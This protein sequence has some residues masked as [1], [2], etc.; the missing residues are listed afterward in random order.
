MLAALR[1]DPAVSGLAFARHFPIMDLVP[2]VVVSESL[3]QKQRDV[4]KSCRATN[5]TTQA[6]DYTSED[7]GVV[8]EEHD[9]KFWAPLTRLPS[10]RV[11]ARDYGRGD[12][13][14]DAIE[15]A[16]GGTKSSSKSTC[17]WSILA[18]A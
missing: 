15:S 18:L 5:P 9:A 8:I 13:P 16:R 11:V 17:R 3:Q 10:S 12:A 4:M 1:T 6:I 2:G 14:K 7:S